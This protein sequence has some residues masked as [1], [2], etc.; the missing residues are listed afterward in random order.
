MR[1]FVVVL[2]IIENI[3]NQF[4]HFPSYTCIP[5]AM[6]EILKRYNDEMSMKDHDSIVLATWV[7]YRVF[8]FIL[9]KMVMVE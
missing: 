8:S 4:V 3:G 5:K 9:L 7:Y 1:H 2:N 6:S